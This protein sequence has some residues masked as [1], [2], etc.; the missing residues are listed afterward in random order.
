[1]IKEFK[2][3]LQ[4]G[5]LADAYKVSANYRSKTL[6]IW[7]IDRSKK[8][9]LKHLQ[10]SYLSVQ[11]IEKVMFDMTFNDLKQ[12]LKTDIFTSWR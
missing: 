7:T 8:R 2:S 3:Y 5:K 9:Y 6:R 4:N 10:T 11:E 1:M 12:F